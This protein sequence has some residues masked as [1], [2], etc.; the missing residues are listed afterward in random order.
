R[1]SVEQ[2]KASK[3]GLY[4][5]LAAAAPHE[6]EPAWGSLGERRWLRALIWVAVLLVAVG[7]VGMWRT[8]VAMRRLD[9]ESFVSSSLVTHLV[10][11]VIVDP[12]KY[13][14]PV[15]SGSSAGAGVGRDP[16]QALAMLD[17][18]Q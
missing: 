15:N 5:D 7:G 10:P 6:V 14:A 13:L 18:K 1:Q 17:E 4:D 16:L 8:E 9:R 3:G 11:G 12:G 2:S